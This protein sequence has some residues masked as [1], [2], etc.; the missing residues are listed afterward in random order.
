MDSGAKE[1]SA[2]WCL[3]FV[4][5]PCLRVFARK[6]RMCVLVIWYQQSTVILVLYRFSVKGSGWNS[7]WLLAFSPAWSAEFPR[8][9]EAFHIRS[10]AS[11][12]LF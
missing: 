5:L 2:A 12:I 11:E 4:I 9:L 8:E 10:S 7:V 1:V 3:P 6:R